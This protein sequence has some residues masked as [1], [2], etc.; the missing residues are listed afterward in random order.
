VRNGDDVISFPLEVAEKVARKTVHK[1]LVRGDHA[2]RDAHKILL[3]NALQIFYER[4][5]DIIDVCFIAPL[6]VVPLLMVALIDLRHAG[7]EDALINK[8]MDQFNEQAGPEDRA[9][10]IKHRELLF[11]H[12]STIALF[13]EYP[14]CRLPAAV[15][16]RLTQKGSV[17][18][19]HDLRNVFQ[20]SKTSQLLVFCAMLSALPNQMPEADIVKNDHAVQLWTRGFSHPKI[21]RLCPIL[22]S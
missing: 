5:N 10:N 18:I 13:F 12:S 6:P 8:R 14:K 22:F 21:E 17:R 16:F 11:L 20:Q 9:V 19:A 3:A 1:I 15:K 2:L 4:D 7:L